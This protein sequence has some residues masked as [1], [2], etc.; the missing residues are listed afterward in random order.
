[1]KKV[2]V[3]GAN[4]MMG[5]DLCRILVDRGY[6]L[7]ATDIDTL[8]IRDEEAVNDIVAD[9]QPDWVAHLAALTNVD[10]CEKDPDSAFLANTIGT[11]NVALACQKHDILMS[12]VSTLSVFDGNKCSPYTEYD[13]PNPLNWYAKSKY[14]GERIVETL[15]NRYYIVRAGWMFGGG[16]DDKKFVAK[17]IELAESR[18]RLTI[19]DD[20]FGSPTYTKDIS[21]G[22]ERLAR[23]GMHGR[24]HMLN[25]GGFCNRF[26]FAKA[27]MQYAGVTTCELEPVTSAHF[28]LPAPRPR[29]EAGRNY[30]L[31]LRGTN[32]MRPW[33]EALAE[34]IE[35]VLKYGNEKDEP[36][37]AEVGLYRHERVAA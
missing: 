32:W 31:D 3:T 13:T 27:I 7:V 20:K 37:E 1:M 14:E 6:D 10:E 2:L 15:L 36:L 5:K 18:D 17:I 16:P 9:A 12:Y 26:E 25:T 28:P 35:Q 8:D 23:S 4:G 30:N 24:Y 34:Y 19:V 11:Q 29:M 22:I 33:R 21:D